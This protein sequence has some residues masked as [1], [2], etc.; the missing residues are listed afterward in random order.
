MTNFMNT[1]GTATRRIPDAIAPRPMNVWVD[2][3][4]TATH[5]GTFDPQR[6]VELGRDAARP[7]RRRRWGTAG[8]GCMGESPRA[9][10]GG[11]A[12]TEPARPVKARPLLAGGR[13][14]AAR[15]AASGGLVL[16]HS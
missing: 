9:A 3:R 2:A 16:P 5:E 7:T 10:H 13:A 1:K 14:E 15:E 4:L 11:R 6:G 8:V 12:R